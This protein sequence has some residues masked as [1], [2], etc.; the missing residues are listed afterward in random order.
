[1]TSAQIDLFSGFILMAIG[2]VLVVIMLI[3]HIY[4]EAIESRLSNCSYVEDNKR[5]W[6]NAGLL[7]KVMRGGIISMVL[8]MPK[9]HAKRGLIDVQELSRLPKRYRYL[10]MIPFIACCVLLVFLIALSAGEKY[11]A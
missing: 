5:V 10:L 3:A 7:G 2:L 6:S 9:M 8:I 1:M 11:I 4:V